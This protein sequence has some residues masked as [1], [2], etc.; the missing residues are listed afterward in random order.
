MQDQRLRILAIGAHPDDSDFE[1]GGVAALYARRGHQVKFLS[2]TNGDAGHYKMGGAELAQRRRAEALKAA[3]TIGIQYEVLDIHDEELM[4]TLETRRRVIQVIREFQPHLVMTH[5]PNDYHPDHRYTSTLVQ[6]AAY[7]VTVAGTLALT[8]H[9]RTNPVFVYFSDR[10]QKPYPFVP[11]VVVG[12]DQVVEKKVDMLHCHESQVYEW[13]PYNELYLEQ[14]PRDKSL[15]RAWLRQRLEDSLR[16]DAD[17]FREKLI[18]LYGEQRAAAIKY[19]E[20]FECCEYG[21]ALT[22]EN[23]RRLFPF[24]DS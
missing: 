22:G 18:E 4:P 15:R 5:R 8:E 1:A 7:L 23:I 6:D 11:D 2:L 20:A 24:F 9:L 21:L 10:F 16:E 17:R 13:L 14:V 12:I 19:A 3:A